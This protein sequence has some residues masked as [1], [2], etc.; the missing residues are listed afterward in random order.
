LAGV[1]TVKFIEYT[2]LFGSGSACG[3]ELS[4]PHPVPAI[5]TGTTNVAADSSQ[6]DFMGRLPRPSFGR[7]LELLGGRD[8]AAPM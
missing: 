3:V 5:A 2:P 6:I 4:P 1:L 7:T 8:D